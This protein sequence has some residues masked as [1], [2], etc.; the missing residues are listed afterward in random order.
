MNS[1]KN[2]YET[3]RGKPAPSKYHGIVQTNIGFLFKL[4]Y[5]EKYAG[6]LS[7]YY[8]RSSV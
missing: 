7:C 1:N 5:G 4:H 3:E 6:W 8:R 2:S